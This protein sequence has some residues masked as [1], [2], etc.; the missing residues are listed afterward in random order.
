MYAEAEPW[1]RHWMEGLRNNKSALV[2]VDDETVTATLAPVFAPQSE[3]CVLQV[4][5]VFLPKLYAIAAPD[6]IPSHGP[7]QALRTF[8]LIRI[9]ADSRH[10]CFSPSESDQPLLRVK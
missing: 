5:A 8:D 3:R 1:R 10:R 4:T 6:G 9:D 2:G 7:R